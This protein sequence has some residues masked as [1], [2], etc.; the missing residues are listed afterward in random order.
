VVGAGAKGLEGY[1]AV[2]SFFGGLA[3]VPRPSRCQE[4]VPEEL[5][6]FCRC[7]MQ[8]ALAW[9]A[10]P[11]RAQYARSPPEWKVEQVFVHL[12]AALTGRRG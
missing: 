5:G 10:K 12:P 7:M 9:A 2:V 11:E 1:L 8:C 4:H 3:D 6:H